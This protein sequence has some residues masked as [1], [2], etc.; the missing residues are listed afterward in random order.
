M[1]IKYLLVA[2]TKPPPNFV[3]CHPSKVCSPRSGR[4]AGV[5]TATCPA[6]SGTAP[7]ST[8]SNGRANPSGRSQQRKVLAGIG[9]SIPRNFV[10]SPANRGP[11]G[12]RFQPTPCGPEPHS[13]VGPH[14]VPQRADDYPRRFASLALLAMARLP[15]FGFRS[16]LPL[17]RLGI[18]RPTIKDSRAPRTPPRGV[19]PGL[20]VGHCL[21]G[22]GHCAINTY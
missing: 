11:A 7:L 22:Y 14:E 17:R 16:R 19:R 4:P 13:R 12:S 2:T 20:G 15:G 9:P 10:R 5:P 18:L 8:C 3:G 21:A 1:R 6:P